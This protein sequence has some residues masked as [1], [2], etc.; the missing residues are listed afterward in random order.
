MNDQ[1][2]IRP[3]TVVEVDRALRSAG[4]HSIE[5]AAL[6]EG[7]VHTVWAKDR[8]IARLSQGWKPERSGEGGIW[9]RRDRGRLAERQP[10]TAAECTVYFPPNG[11]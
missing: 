11:R 6:L 8:V 4:E 3:L 1:T 10:M 9:V 5:T 2:T 7:L